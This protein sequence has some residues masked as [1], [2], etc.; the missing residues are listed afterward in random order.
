MIFSEKFVFE[1]SIFLYLL[2]PTIVNDKMQVVVPEGCE[3]PQVYIEYVND[4]TA[5]INGYI[6]RLQ[7]DKKADLALI[8]N[9]NNVEDIVLFDY[10]KRQNDTIAMTLSREDAAAIGMSLDNYDKQIEVLTLFDADTT[11]RAGTMERTAI[12]TSIFLNHNVLKII[13][14]NIF[15]NIENDFKTLNEKYKNSL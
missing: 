7:Q 9:N 5:M 4:Y 8:I 1:K 11:F 3:I 6:S 10:M 12:Y 2:Q 13:E 15:N 14:E